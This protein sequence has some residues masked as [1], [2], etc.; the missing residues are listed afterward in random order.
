MAGKYSIYKYS[1]LLSLV[2]APISL[3]ANTI[4]GPQ[5][6]AEFSGR[7]LAGQDSLPPGNSSASAFR[8]S[9]E[10]ILHPG[11]TIA[12]KI[13]SNLFV[14]AEV[15]KPE[16]FIGEPLIV[17]YKL[18][19][20]LNA[21]SSITR[22]PALNGFSKNELI[23]SI[24]LRNSAERIH[25]KLFQV[26]VLRKTLLVPQVAGNLEID[27]MEVAH[28]ISFITLGGDATPGGSQLTDLLNQI[29]KEERASSSPRVINTHSTGLAVKVKELP[30]LNKPAHF[31]GAVGSFTMEARVLSTKSI[32]N[33]FL[34]IVVEIR[35]N[36]DL[37]LIEP[38]G[39]QFPKE[40]EFSHVNTV[41]IAEIPRDGHD[42]R[43]IFEYTAIAR[44]SGHTRIPPVLFSYFDPSDQS[45]KNI[46]TMPL[47]IRIHE[48]PG[49]LPRK[50][51][52]GKKSITAAPEADPTFVPK[53]SL[54]ILV[55]LLV[56]SMAIIWKKILR[57]VQ[58]ALASVNKGLSRDAKGESAPT[59]MFLAVERLKNVKGM[60]EA[61]DFTT[62]YYELNKTLWEVLTEKLCLLPAELNKGAILSALSS[63]GW[64]PEDRWNLEST[65]N[66]YER[67]LYI[68]G[69][70]DE[71]DFEAAFDNALAIIRKLE[72]LSAGDMPKG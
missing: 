32:V 34:K 48:N 1:L 54:L 21:T 52:A 27:P 17:T 38:P 24:S 9:N 46:Q 11:E 58:R 39:I 13:R 63:K 71:N 8:S 70:K 47:T 25:G 61:K 12:D 7:G 64:S 66:E 10:N 60:L 72:Q 35:G 43:R 67:N 29:K 36:G 15:T 62:C 68:P 6:L 50:V 14:K 28:K 53:Q 5:C 69:Y 23:K 37:S 33:E 30:V 45:Y 22:Q 19:S 16:C 26:H 42:Y 57:F 59:P 4:E 55:G 2:A 20:R 49:Q 41:K 65:M 40:I 44:Q 51:E 31:S 3:I 18:Y 56:L